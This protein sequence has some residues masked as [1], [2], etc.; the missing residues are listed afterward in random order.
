MD[1]PFLQF[2]GQR[3][4]CSGPEKD[5]FCSICNC[6][7]NSEISVSLQ[8]LLN[9]AEAYSELWSISEMELFAKTVTDWKPF[10]IFSKKLHLRYLTVF[11]ICRVDLLPW[12]LF[13]MSASELTLNSASLSDSRS[14]GQNMKLTLVTVYWSYVPYLKNRINLC[15]KL[16][17]NTIISMWFFLFG[18]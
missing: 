4:I 8:K 7:L 16:P 2:S 15:F 18:G 11:W 14:C 6:T 13:W 10:I 12:K 3:K 17:K 1:D 9:M 5:D